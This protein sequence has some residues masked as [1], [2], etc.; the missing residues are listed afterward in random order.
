MYSNIHDKDKVQ[1]MK[2]KVLSEV[3]LNMLDINSFLSFIQT[4]LDEQNRKERQRKY[5]WL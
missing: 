3:G 1:R 2:T 5:N 4:L